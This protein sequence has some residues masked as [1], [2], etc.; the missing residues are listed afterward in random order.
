MPL[1]SAAPDD[2]IHGREEL[3]IFLR[4]LHQDFQRHGET[5]ENNTL[6]GFLEALAAWVNDCPASY[7]NSGRELPAGGDWTFMAHALQAATIYE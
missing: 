2:R 3:V 5:W 1:S 6:D 7:R 4:E